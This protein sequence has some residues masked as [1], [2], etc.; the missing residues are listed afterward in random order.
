MLYLVVL[1]ATSVAFVICACCYAIVL[2]FLPFI[3]DRQAPYVGLLLFPGLFFFAVEQYIL[4]TSYS[5]LPVSLS[6]REIGKHSALLFLQVLGL[7]AMLCTLYTYQRLCR[8]L[9]TQTALQSLS[10]AAQTQKIYIAEAQMRY[11]QTKAFRHDIRNHLSVLRGLLNSG[12]L[13][14]SKVYLQKLETVSSSLSFLYQSGNPVVDILL[15]E[16]LEMAKAN[17]IAADIS[18]IL[19]RPCGIDD[20]DL[21]VIFANALD[22]AINACQ[23][24]QGAKSIQIRGE[25]QGDYYMLAFDNTCAD[26]P[27]SPMG[28]GLSNIKS[29]AEKYHGAM[30]TEKEEGQYSL[31]VLLNIS[32][33]P[34]NISN[35]KP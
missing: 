7:G 22:N 28:T 26:G 19:P 5:I 8:S 14:E 18:L 12:K 24:V 10:Q 31:S 15:G 17:G 21:C 33:P 2:K 23:S 16:K 1:L 20:F 13:D 4:E 3:E 34:E 25:R 11:E 6:V 27:M 35:Q 29:V 9:Q 32:L 30:M